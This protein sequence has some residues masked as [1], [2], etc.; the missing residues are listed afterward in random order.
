MQIMLARFAEGDFRLALVDAT[1]G[2]VAV[3]VAVTSYMARAI[4]VA[5]TLAAGVKKVGAV[6]PAA[7]AQFIIAAFG[8]FT[9]L[10]LGGG[11]GLLLQLVAVDAPTVP[12]Y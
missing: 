11:G 10:D 9:A 2:A 7:Q 3:G 8:L 12:A 4:G 6:V 1:A 5:T